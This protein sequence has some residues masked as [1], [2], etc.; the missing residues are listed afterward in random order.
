MGRPLGSQRL[1]QLSHGGLGHGVRGHGRGRAVDRPRRDVHDVPGALRDHGPHGGLTAVEDASEVD[2]EHPVEFLIGD[3]HH[4]PSLRTPAMLPITSIRPW[5]ATA[6]AT[7]SSTSARWVTSIS[8][9]TA[10]P[11]RPAISLAVVLDAGAVDIAEHHR[12]ARPGE[13]Q[14]G[15]FAD[16]AGRA[17]QH[18]HPIGQAEGLSRCHVV[19]QC[20]HSDPRY[21]PPCPQATARLATV[22]PDTRRG[23]NV[24]RGPARSRFHAWSEV[25]YRPSRGVLRVAHQSTCIDAARSWCAPPVDECARRRETHHVHSQA[26]ADPRQPQPGSGCGHH[27]RPC[28]RLPSR[29][30]AAEPGGPR[31]DADDLRAGSVP[32]CNA[33]RRPRRYCRTGE[34]ASSSRGALERRQR[35][36]A[37]HRVGQ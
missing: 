10:V 5:S 1:G 9:A 26:L 35:C 30:P 18:C 36:P 34:P 19:R 32:E 24:A 14:C 7:S 13:D 22:W 23:V 25:A 2:V 3:V 33:G 12:G 21:P 28:G 16:T 11:P 6:R 29:H 37:L 4:G 31:L 17:G 27:P 15:R 20:L 8:T